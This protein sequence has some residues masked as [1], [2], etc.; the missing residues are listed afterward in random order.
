MN[1]YDLK[2]NEPMLTGKFKK[3]GYDWWWHNFTGI[4]EETGEEKTFFIEYFT[5]NPALGGAE[6]VLGQLEENKKNGKKPSYLMVKAGWWGKDKLSFI[7][8][9]VGMMLL[10]VLTKKLVFLLKQRTTNVQKLN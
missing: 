7:V 9:S 8:L 3:Q 2:R 4:D 6:P 5:V 10:S 1:K